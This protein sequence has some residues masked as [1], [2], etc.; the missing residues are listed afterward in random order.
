M[1]EAMPIPETSSEAATRLQPP[2]LRPTE[3]PA[4]SMLPGR[5]GDDA[6]AQQF[7]EPAEPEEAVMGMLV[8][9]PFHLRDLDDQLGCY[10]CFPDIRVRH[11]GKYSLRFSLMR[12]PS[13]EP[14][15]TE[16]ENILEYVFSTAFTVYTLKDFP[17]VDESTPLSKKFA[18]Q[19]V[20]IPIRNKTRLKA[21]A[22]DATSFE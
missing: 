21:D 4:G 22:E 7:Q 15:T 5:E 3:L 11:P 14:A 13:T 12:M 20:G 1:H 8:S 19:G 16:P 17:G 10:Y 18:L 6:V 2:P 9:A